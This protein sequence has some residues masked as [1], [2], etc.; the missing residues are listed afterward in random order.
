MQEGITSRV[1][2]ADRPYGEFYDFYSISQ[3]YF[4]YTLVIPQDVNFLFVCLY[5]KF[6]FF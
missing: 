6:T 3:E 1:M 5:C 4:G 2:A